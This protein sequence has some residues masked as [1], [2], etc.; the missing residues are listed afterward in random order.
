MADKTYKSITRPYNNFL[1]RETDDSSSNSFSSP[2][3][4]SNGAASSS[5]A[6]SSSSS[7]GS[8]ETMPV[9]SDGNIGDVWIKNFI[10]SENWKPK[11]IGFYIDGRS[12]V[13]EFSKVFV[14]GEVQAESGWFGGESGW[15]IS[16]GTIKDVAGVVGLSSLV[17]LSDDVRFWAGDV[18]PLV[19]PFYVTK[20]GVIAASS[21][22]VGGCALSPTSIGSSYFVSGPLGFGWNVSNSGT[23][24]F[25]NVSIRGVIRTSVFEKDTISAVNGLVMI[26][27]ADVLASDMTALNTST[28]TITGETTF[29]ANEVV[30]IKDGVDD[31][32]MLVTD[33][34]GAPIYTVTRDLA[35]SYVSDVNPTWKKGTAVVSMGVG[36]GSKTG[37]VLLDSSSAYSPFV[38]VY[39]RNSNTY[40]DYSLHGRFGWLK[41]I[42]DADVG[43]ATTDVWGLYTDNA[44]IKG[45]IVAN[46]GYI[47]GNTGWVIEAGRMRDVAGV[48]GM[49]SVITAGDDIRFWA[50]HAT[51]AS[52]PFRVTESGALVATMATISGSITATTGSIGGWTVDADSIKD[53]A[54]VVGLSS[55]VTAGDDIRFWAGDAIAASAPFRVTEAGA[56]VATSATVTGVINATSGKFGTSTNYWSV[57]ATG[58]RAVSASADV[59]IAY[60]KTDFGQDSTAGFM[61]GYDFS[62]SAAKFEVGS[63][64]SNMIKYDGATLSIRGSLNADDITA[65]T[66]SGRTVKATGG[67]VDVWLDSADGQL[68]FYSG[69]TKV[70]YVTGYNDGTHGGSVEIQADNYL[71]L[72]ANKWLQ[73]NYNATGGSGEYLIYNE[74]TLVFKLD[75]ANNAFFAGSIQ[76]GAIIAGSSAVGCGAITSTSDIRCGGTFKSSDNSS[77]IDTSFYSLHWMG[78]GGD[79]A[80]RYT[81]KTVTVKDGLITALSAVSDWITPEAI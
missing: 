36:A 42:T 37:F 41:G 72:K 29:V 44:Y 60:G 80:I 48:V 33:A 28:V 69:S 19:A 12:G 68:K 8:V 78:Q 57:G 75:D 9:R 40:S 1:T 14:N 81:R 45:V 50:G 38:D 18:N 70:G 67:A 11:R 4:A 73:V 56:L 15:M 25:Q 66:I 30:R 21:G 61:L 71:H 62:A 17:T 31:E 16:H 22:T 79:K 51:M 39:G 35:G 7:N 59:I 54:G 55:A 32:W 27:K 43:L 26:S 5:S 6:S 2:P 3:T 63:S 74:N 13:A 34:S 76:C 20:S 77:G 65:G 46:T 10:R 64:A 49:S 47:G 52:A 23:A 53:V 58:L 24:E